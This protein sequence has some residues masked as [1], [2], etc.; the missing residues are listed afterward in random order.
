NIGFGSGLTT[1]TLL[2]STAITSVDTIEIEPAMIEGA[3]TFGAVVARA[4][5]DPRSNI[6]IEDA[7]SFFAGRNE[8]YD[9]IVSEPSNPWVSGVS[10]LF[11]DEF[12]KQVKRYVRD[13]GVLVQWIQLY[14]I[15]TELVLSML[16]AL[17]NNFEDYVAYEAGPADMVILAVPKG[18]VPPLSDAV[19]AMPLVKADFE[20]VGVKNVGDLRM[21]RIASKRHL[22]ILAKSHGVP[23]NSDYFP[24]VD[25]RAP[26]LR[27]LGRTALDLSLLSSASVPIIDMLDR[28][29]FPGMES[30]V[31]PIALQSQRPQRAVIAKSVRDVILD[32][33]VRPGT[34][35]EQE[36]LLRSTFIRDTLIGCIDVENRS[37]I[38]D[39]LFDLGPLLSSQLAKAE[40]AAL[41][42]KIEAAKCHARVSVETRN[43]IAVFKAVSNRDA[44]AMALAAER[45]LDSAAP[46]TPAQLEYLVLAGMAGHYFSGNAEAARSLWLKRSKGLTDEGRGSPPFRLMLGLLAENNVRRAGP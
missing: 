35:I 46:S 43:L 40:S 15:D 26:K 17:G 20:R 44:N 3:R 36:T 37:A 1:H 11:S 16:K 9:V 6:H 45:V 30:V 22:E 8:K 7:K 33:V 42:Q 25:L 10:G 28:Y 38:R 41:W 29:D 19:F 39:V 4:F 5:N 27:F 18:S 31:S 24:V 34:K 12:Y 23:G 13:D 32:G 2:G 14:E 21:R